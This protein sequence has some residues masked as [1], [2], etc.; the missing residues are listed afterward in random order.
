MTLLDFLAGLVTMGF[1]VAALFFARFWRDS[2]D[3]LFL[4][5]AI[6]FLLLGIVQAL[7]SIAHIPVEERSWVYLLRLLAF[8]IIIW[9]ILRKN[10]TIR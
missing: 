5:F 7:L 6:A 9:A 2:R 8:L 3:S 1:A 4:C 10:V